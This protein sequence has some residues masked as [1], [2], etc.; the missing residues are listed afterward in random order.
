MEYIAYLSKTA[1][2]Q[3]F[4]QI[5]DTLQTVASW[6]F[7]TEYVLSFLR[8]NHRTSVALGNIFVW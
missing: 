2:G 3:L 6:I 8:Y 4:R 5:I 1:P 7:T